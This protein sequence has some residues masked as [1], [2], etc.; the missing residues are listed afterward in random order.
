MIPFEVAI[1]TFVTHQVLVGII[2]PRVALDHSIIGAAPELVPDND[3][4]VVLQDAG[5]CLGWG[6]DFWSAKHLDFWRPSFMCLPMLV[7]DQQ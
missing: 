2:K 4:T 7:A 1:T 5:D 6:L 3:E